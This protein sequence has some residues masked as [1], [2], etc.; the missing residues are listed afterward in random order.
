MERQNPST[1]LA[2]NESMTKELKQRDYDKIIDALENL[3]TATYDKI[4]DYLFFSDSS[5]VSKRLKE[6]EGL[7]LI[8]K[9]GEKRLTKSGR[10]A[11]VYRRLVEGETPPTIEKEHYL[12][13]VTTA[14]DYASKLIAGSKEGRLMQKDIFDTN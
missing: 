13:G 12:E 7:S 5:R 10:N 11:N 6:M 2:A 4:G 8:C 9:T 1:S 14:A 3:G